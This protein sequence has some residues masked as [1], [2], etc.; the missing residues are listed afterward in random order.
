MV[1]E[2]LLTDVDSEAWWVDSALSRH[3]AKMRDFFVDMKEVKAG[4]HRVY[5]GNKTYYDVLGI[6]TVKIMTLG[7]RNLYLSDVLF[8]PT[9]RCNLISIPCLDEKGRAPLPL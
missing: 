7:E 2:S 1:Y 6:E 4:D 9:M 5:M 3:V 8:A